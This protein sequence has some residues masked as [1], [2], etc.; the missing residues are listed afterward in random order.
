MGQEP[1]ELWNENCW[2]F[3]PNGAGACGKVHGRKVFEDSALVK[4]Q[5]FPTHGVRAASEPPKPARPLEWRRIEALEALIDGGA[6]AQQRVM[7]GFFV[8]FIL[9]HSS[10]RCSNGQSSRKLRFTEVVVMGEAL[11]K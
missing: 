7:A 4:S 5:V 11:L 1:S 10:H 8:L 6:T 3:G 9:I 2:M